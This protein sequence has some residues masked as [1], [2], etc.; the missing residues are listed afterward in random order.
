MLCGIVFLVTSYSL[1]LYE[2]DL[3]CV[4]A[5]NILIMRA[6]YTAVYS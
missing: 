6:S 3:K 1:A 2:L 4:A 5:L